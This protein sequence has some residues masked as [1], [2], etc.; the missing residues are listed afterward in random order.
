MRG[1][2]TT[3]TYTIRTSIVGLGSNTNTDKQLPGF[4][5]APTVTTRSSMTAMG[6]EQ[7][8]GTG[9]EMEGGK[10]G[11]REF[12]RKSDPA[13][14]ILHYDHLAIQTSS[15]LG[16]GS[17]PRPCLS[18]HTLQED[19][20]SRGGGSETGADDRQKNVVAAALYK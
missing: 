1:T 6:V 16:S 9:I 18:P 4:V 7:G 14:S 20:G 3:A 10:E 17:S 15:E 11:E 19:K 12:R 5:L 13:P 2:S 8:M